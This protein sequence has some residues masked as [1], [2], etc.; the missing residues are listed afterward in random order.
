MRLHRHGELILKSV[1]HI[2]DEARLV[3][4]K[5]SLIVAHSESGHHHT[6]TAPATIRFLEHEGKTYLDIPLQAKLQHQKAGTETHGT[7]VIEPG[8]YERIIKRS[9]SYAEKVMRRVQD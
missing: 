3:E 2:P 7:Q 5:K 1:T 9:Y 8:L 4:N 6:L